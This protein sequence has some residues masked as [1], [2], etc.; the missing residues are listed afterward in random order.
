MK[1][2]PGDLIERAIDAEDWVK[3]RKLIRLGLKHEPND[4]W[5]LSRLALTYYEQRQYL[6]ALEIEAKALQS[7]P[8]CPLAIWGYAGSLD[9]LGR[10]KEALKLYQRL[11]SWGEDDL[12]C[13]E[14]GEGIR[15]ARSLIADCHYRIALIWEELGQRKKA[16]TAY[17]EHFARRRPGTH[18]IYPL[19]EVKARYKRLNGGKKTS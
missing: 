18:S 15:A 4:H 11:L 7:A 10:R 2:S 3:A 19:R 1:N 6:R 9:M 17:A 16:L 14:C 5:L 8:F 13:G 12:A